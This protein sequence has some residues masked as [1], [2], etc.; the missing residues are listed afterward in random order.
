MADTKQD[1]VIVGN[2]KSFALTQG[3]TYDVIERDGRKITIV[4]DNNV[5]STYYASVFKD[6]GK[7][8]AKAE[9]KPKAVVLP[10]TPEIMESFNYDLENGTI[11]FEVQ[12]NPFVFAT[13]LGNASTNISCGVRQIFGLN[14]FID[15]CTEYLEENLPHIPA[16][17]RDEIVDAMFVAGVK[18][19][20]EN[21]T[22][23]AMFLASTNTNYAEFSR[24][25]AQLSPMTVA[26]HTRM[27]PNSNNE[28]KVWVLDQQ[29]TN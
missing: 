22:Q 27:N 21:V 6:E 19:L 16:E 9:A 25:D 20:M 1:Q 4:N 10:T 29:F 2:P 24:L 3:N 18:A 15:S 11:G 5:T 28:I 23:V 8:K 14:N 17:L 7:S 26:S 13:G 12:G